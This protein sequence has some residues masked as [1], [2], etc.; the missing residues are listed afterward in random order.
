[1]AILPIQ[2]KRLLAMSNFGTKVGEVMEEDE[3]SFR[4]VYK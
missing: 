3:K 2:I 1:M 4:F